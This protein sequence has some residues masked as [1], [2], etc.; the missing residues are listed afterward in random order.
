MLNTARNQQDRAEGPPT[1]QTPPTL[2]NAGARAER[3]KALN[4]LHGFLGE[5]VMSEP[6]PH[7]FR[8]RSS[9]KLEKGQ[10]PGNPGHTEIVDEAM[11]ET[12]G[13]RMLDNNQQSLWG[14]NCLIYAGRKVIMSM[15]AGTKEKVSKEGKV[16]N[17]Y[18][19]PPPPPPPGAL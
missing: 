17:P 6:G 4:L 12:W 5:M 2:A 3:P 8:H 10:G 7:P 11:I 14:L 1:N 15:K 18:R 16:H 19:P 9:E 13:T